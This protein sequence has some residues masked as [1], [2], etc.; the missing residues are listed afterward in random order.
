[1]VTSGT[2]QVVLIFSSGDDN[3]GKGITKFHIY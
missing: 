1:M 2:Y 3:A